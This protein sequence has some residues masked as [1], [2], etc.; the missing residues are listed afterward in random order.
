M[1]S[2]K[3]TPAGPKNSRYAN[4]VGMPML[5][6][7]PWGCN[8]YS[9]PSAT[10]N[11]GMSNRA[12]TSNGHTRRPG[13]LVRCTPHAKPRETA[14]ARTAHRALSHSESSSPWAKNPVKAARKLVRVNQAWPWSNSRGETAWTRKNRIGTINNR[15][16]AAHSTIPLITR[17]PASSSRL[18]QLIDGRAPA[19]WGGDGPGGPGGAPGGVAAGS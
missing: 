7:T 15:A 16:S 9:H 4:P 10:R 12:H 18:R 13:R 3:T 17:G 11:D 2:T 5:D 1:A 6:R 8:R 19:G 14:R